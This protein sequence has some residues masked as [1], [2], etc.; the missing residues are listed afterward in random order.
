MKL[1]EILAL[2]LVKLLLDR[3]LRDSVELSMFD[4]NRPLTER[5]EELL[6]S[7]RSNYS[8][9]GFFNKKFIRE[10]KEICSMIDNLQAAKVLHRQNPTAENRMA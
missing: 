7:I 3:D 2:R 6:N 1:R 4:S 10:D 5:Y 9:K 8:R